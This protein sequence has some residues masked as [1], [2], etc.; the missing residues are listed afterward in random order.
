MKERDAISYLE[1]Y[2]Q[3]KAE[4]KRE[5]VEWLEEK[6]IFEEGCYP[7]LPTEDWQ[8]LKKEAGIE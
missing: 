1:G 5:V 4:G 7:R 6:M 8:A 2:Q 3:G